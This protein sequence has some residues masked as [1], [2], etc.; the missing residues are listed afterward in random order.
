M[1]AR[2]SNA[3]NSSAVD[4]VVVGA[5]FAGM[6]ALHKLRGLGFSVRVFE[7]GGDVGGV[8]YWNRYPGARCDIDSMEYSYSFSEA[9]QQEWQW[10]E[11]FASAPEILRYAQHVA[12]RF[13]LKRDITFGTEVTAATFDEARSRWDVVTD[14]GE[15]VTAQFVVLAVGCLSNAR[16]PPMPGME[17][18][19]GRV[20]HTG[21]WPDE[22]VDFS[23]QRVGIVGNG[24]SGVQAIPRIAEQA[25]ELTVFQRTATYTVPARN[26]P[27]DPAYVARIKADY[28][29][30][31]AR[32]RAMVGGAGAERIPAEPKSALEATP[33]EREQAFLRRWQFGGMGL[34]ATYLDLRA[35]LEA[36]EFLAQ[37]LR[38]QIKAIVKDPARAEM[39]TPKHVAGCKRMCL[40][41]G[42]Y[43]AFNRPNV[44]L[45]DVKATP[46]ETFTERG[47]QVSGQVHELDVMVFATGYDAM[48]G[49]MLAIDIRGRGG[50][51]LREA[52]SA[53]PRT[54]LG[55]GT[56]GFPNLFI[57]AGPGSPSVLANV[58]VA[59]EQHVEWLAD[60]LT[61][62]REHRIAAIEA[63][64]PAQ[65]AWVE[66]VNAVAAPTVYHQCDSWYLGANV[67]GKPRVF[68]PLIGFPPY[69]AKCNEVAARGY[70]G[71]DLTPQSETASA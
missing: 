31:R 32:N 30:F 38:K 39:L 9:L 3:M 24:S 21:Q 15:R 26:A 23:G 4:V 18:F 46:I 34:Q 63:Q 64:L 52:W 49:A 59:I 66:H 71:F 12:E 48:T 50:L 53:G 58:I 67:P 28:A 27:L 54:Y 11:R 20:L 29:G 65:D 47:V 25:A 51:T 60:C 43:E 16:I 35:N 14:G 7:R 56:A 62:L 69:V 70:E 22:G 17:R 8:W 68:M 45:V 19:R 44:H 13:D 10:T 42:Y 1:N 61:Y 33:E 5:G 40:D 41:T 57:M 36:N 2:R 55:L 6:Y 37:F